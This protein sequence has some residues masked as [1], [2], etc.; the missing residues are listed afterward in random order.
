MVSTTTA[1]AVVH[2]AAPVPG[3]AL[4][5]ALARYAPAL[6]AAIATPGLYTLALERT[7]WEALRD[8]ILDDYEG[9]TA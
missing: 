7:L 1:V 3:P 9:V 5:E 4:R 2:P 6:S 8:A